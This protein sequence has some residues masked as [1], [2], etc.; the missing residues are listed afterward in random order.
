MICLT[1]VLEKLD[2]LEVQGQRFLETDDVSVDLWFPRFTDY[3]MG[4]DDY[5]FKKALLCTSR[6]ML[7]FTFIPRITLLVERPNIFSVGAYVGMPVIA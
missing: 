3:S 7:I 2:M 5:I 1:V 4:I 6:S